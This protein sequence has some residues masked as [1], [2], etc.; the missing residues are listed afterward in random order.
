MGK[1]SRYRFISIAAV[2]LVLLTG[3]VFL[4]AGCGSSAEDNP[5]EIIKNVQNDAG[6]AV[7][8]TNLQML[9]TAIQAYQM[10]NNGE[11]PTD[12]SQ[13]MKYTSKGSLTD[14]M[15]GT[16]YLYVENGETKAAVR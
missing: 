13:L 6:N 5:G 10:E 4:A 2:A 3:T 11:A 1:Q 12:I 14:P 15:G 7:R 9:N 16:Y 8:Q